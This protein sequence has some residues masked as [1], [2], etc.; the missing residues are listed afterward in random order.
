MIQKI[1]Y[2]D[3]LLAYRT[4]NTDMKLL[5]QRVI[6]SMK[7]RLKGN[8]IFIAPSTFEDVT[9]KKVLGVDAVRIYH[10]GR[11]NS[12]KLEDISLVDA[13]AIYSLINKH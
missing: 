4:P 13:L 12:T 8:K 10:P 3:A 6:K 9:G 7:L 1:N 11:H 5:Q 2:E